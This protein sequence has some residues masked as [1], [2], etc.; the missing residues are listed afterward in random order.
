MLLSKGRH[1]VFEA[2]TYLIVF[3]EVPVQLVSYMLFERLRAKPASSRAK[4]LR[5]V[6]RK[7]RLRRRLANS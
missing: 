1:V 6:R 3:N 2:P 4:N 5:R 7:R